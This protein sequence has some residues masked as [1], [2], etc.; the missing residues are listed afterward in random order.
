MKI[1]NQ[2]KSGATNAPPA[3]ALQTNRSAAERGASG[4]AILDVREEPKSEDELARFRLELKVPGRRGPTTVYL[5]SHGG[6][7]LPIR[8]SLSPG[9]NAASLS[10]KEVRSLEEASGQSPHANGPA[11]LLNHLLGNRAQQD[12]DWRPNE[13]EGPVPARWLADVMRTLEAGGAAREGYEKA[14]GPT[15]IAQTFQNPPSSPRLEGGPLFAAH[16]S[17]MKVAEPLPEFPPTWRVYD[18]LRTAFGAGPP[19]SGTFPLPNGM[20][21]VVDFAETEGPREPDYRSIRQAGGDAQAAW[22]GWNSAGGGAE[23][24]AFQGRS[25]SLTVSLERADGSRKRLE[26][27]SEH[28]VG[29]KEVSLSN[30]DTTY[31]YFNEW[32]HHLTERP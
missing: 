1:A 16:L 19:R 9:G 30:G 7:D 4:P 6:S 13:L 15:G 31:R 21:M 11:R 18:Y 22:V 5:S 27:Y 23:Y 26:G 25:G 8:L 24:A 17:K 10:A 28:V 14:G 2:P 20:K 3:P 32:Q 29:D 12:K